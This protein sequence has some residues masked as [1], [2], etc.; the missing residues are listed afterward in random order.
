MG[1][2]ANADIALRRSDDL[3]RFDAAT[4]LDQFAIEPRFLEISNSIRDELCLIDGY[5]NRIDHAA[6]LVLGPRPPCRH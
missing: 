2:I 3:A 1:Y 6:G 5:R 4:A